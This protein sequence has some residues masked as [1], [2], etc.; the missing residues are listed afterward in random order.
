MSASF[1]GQDPLSSTGTDD[2]LRLVLAESLHAGPMAGAWWPRSRD[3]QPEAAL[4][5]NRFPSSRGRILRVLVSP[6]DWDGTPR[7]VQ[8]RDG[9][10]TIGMFPGDDRHV[11]VLSLASGARLRLL[12]VD[13]HA[14]AGEAEQLMRA[15]CVARNRR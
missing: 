8:G 9:P 4:L 11:V 7:Q 1:Q 14:A 10:V 5:L 2:P 12:V 13:V 15:S 6:H 3:L